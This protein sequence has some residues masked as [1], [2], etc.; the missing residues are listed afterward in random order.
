MSKILEVLGPKLGWDKEM[1]NKVARL[2]VE[3]ESKEGDDYKSYMTEVE[4]IIPQLESLGTRDYF[5]NHP[6]TISAIKGRLTADFYD[7]VE[8][9]SKSILQEHFK[10]LLGEDALNPVFNNKSLRYADKMTAAFKLLKDSYSLREQSLNSESPE[11]FQKALSEK[12][13]VITS[14]RDEISQTKQNFEKELQSRERGYEVELLKGDLKGILSEM[15]LADRDQSELAFM[16]TWN[17]LSSNYHLKRGESGGIQL[18][19]KDDPTLPANDEETKTRLDIGKYVT[20]SLNKA[21]LLRRN[22][23][24]EEQ[25]QSGANTNG[26]PDGKK[27]HTLPPGVHPESEAAKK[28]E[29]MKQFNMTGGRVLTD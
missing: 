12:D 18:F 22:N 16:Y 14:L 4:K 1:Q 27:T 26:L 6:D 13:S 17:D 28:F 15:P 10:E 7:G 19:Q 29:K 8:T 5:I 21:K 25:K 23:G 24:N 3:P 11:K 9:K 2:M 20:S